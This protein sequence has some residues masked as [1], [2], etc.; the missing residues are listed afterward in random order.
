MDL[1]TCKK[2]KGYSWFLFAFILILPTFI[3]TTHA[4]SHKVPLTIIE[5]DYRCKNLLG[6]YSPQ[7]SINLTPTITPYED[8]FYIF[9]LL[10]SGTAHSIPGLTKGYMLYDLKTHTA[11]NHLNNNEAP[12][13]AYFQ[14]P[15]KQKINFTTY[16]LEPSLNKVG[17]YYC[18]KEM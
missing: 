14:F 3:Q 18:E 8:R 11:V 12:G 10:F 6:G 1:Y 13:L 7:L 4:A 5:G 17:E 15:N 2:Q 16:F 9:Q